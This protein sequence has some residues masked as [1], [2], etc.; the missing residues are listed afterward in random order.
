MASPA[1]DLGPRLAEPAAPARPRALYLASKLPYPP[2]TGGTQRLWHMLVAVAS[3]ADVDIV[4]LTHTDPAVVDDMT[5]EL[6]GV[7]VVAASPTRKPTTLSN[8]AHCLSQRRTP[9]SVWFRDVASL[10]RVLDDWAQASYDVVW[11]ACPLASDLLG[12]RHLGPVIV[13]RYD[14]EEEW[15]RGRIRAEQLW[16]RPWQLARAWFDMRRWTAFSDDRARRAAHVLVCSETDRA[17]LSATNVVVVPN[18]YQRPSN[19]LGGRQSARR[20]R[21]C[22]R[23]R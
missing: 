2:E 7:R 17:R 20:R 15:I 13:D 3:V 9:P 14:L 6:P 10:S 1:Q 4:V 19:P 23:A 12:R 5:R 22:S 18:G 8:L 16:R 11:D 21:C